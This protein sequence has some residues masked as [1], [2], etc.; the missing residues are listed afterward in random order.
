MTLME[1]LIG[2]LTGKSMRMSGIVH[3]DM[4]DDTL[5]RDLRTQLDG[6]LEDRNAALPME[7]YTLVVMRAFRNLRETG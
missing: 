2:D 1:D 5:L 6:L 4:S 3:D 7:A